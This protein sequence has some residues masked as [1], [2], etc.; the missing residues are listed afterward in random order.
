MQNKLYYQKFSNRE[1]MDV[2]EIAALYSNTDKEFKDLVK[3]IREIDYPAVFGTCMHD[4]PDGPEYIDEDQK[5]S[6]IRTFNNNIFELGLPI[7][8]VGVLNETDD[9]ISDTW[10]LEVQHFDL[11]VVQ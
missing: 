3:R 1:E 2:F 6:L 11:E 5:E 8:V 9:E 4:G 7:K 10:R